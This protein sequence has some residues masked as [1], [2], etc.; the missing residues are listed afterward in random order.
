MTEQFLEY[1]HLRRSRVVISDCVRTSSSWQL[2]DVSRA[3]LRLSN[4]L[5]F[6]WYHMYIVSE[7]VNLFLNPVLFH[8]LTGRRRSGML[9][10]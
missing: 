4:D 1:R 2:K 3:P 8:E 5:K 7:I 9:T 6:S 10:I